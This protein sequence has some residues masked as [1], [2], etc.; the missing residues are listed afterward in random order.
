MFHKIYDSL[1][2]YSYHFVLKQVWLK[3]EKF[4]PNND[5]RTR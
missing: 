4:G 2:V 3:L 5:F 1:K